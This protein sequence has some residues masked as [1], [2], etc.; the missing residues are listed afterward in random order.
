VRIGAGHLA[1]AGAGLA[2]GLV[3]G[4]L[5]PREELR[6]ARSEAREA[7][8][9]P[10]GAGTEIAKIFQGKPVATPEAEPAAAP[11]A[12]TPPAPVDDPDEE[13]EGKPSP[14]RLDEMREAMVIRQKQARAALIE[15]AEPSD[16]QLADIDAVFADMNADLRA[17]ATDFVGRFEEGEPSRR[18]MMAFAADSLDVLIDTEDRL[19]ESLTPE[20]RESLSDESLDPLSYVDSSLVDVLGEL[21]R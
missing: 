4:G 12:A 9:S 14:A 2:L 16:E 19:G 13:R 10:G 5:G 11:D 6:E 17:L 7:R 15:D 18:D 3:L 20:Q 8:R 1:F 21:D